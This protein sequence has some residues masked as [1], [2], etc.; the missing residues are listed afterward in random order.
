MSQ[1]P[2]LIIVAALGVI[3]MT[4]TLTLTVAL[5]AGVTFVSFA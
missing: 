5:P 1:R 2:F 4:S 3:A